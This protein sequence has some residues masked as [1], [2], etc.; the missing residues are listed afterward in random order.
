MELTCGGLAK[1]HSRVGS[2]L[3]LANIKLGWKSFTVTNTLAYFI[4]ELVTAVKYFI[5]QTSVA[6]TVKLFTAVFLPYREKLVLV[7]CFYL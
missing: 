2:L 6:C 7:R 3:L 1:L 4:T 5:V